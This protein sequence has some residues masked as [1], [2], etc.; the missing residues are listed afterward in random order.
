MHS[1][2]DF[3][4]M[5]ALQLLLAALLATST[6]TAADDPFVGKW[7]LNPSKCTLTD[8]MKVEAA[9]ANKYALIF[10]G[11]NA[12]TIVADGTDQP[13]LFGT[14]VSITVGGPNAWTVVRKKDGR[15]LLTGI[16]N[17]SADGMTL[18]DHYKENRA[19]GST[20]SLDY[21]YKRTAGSTG[22]PGTWVSTSEKVNSAYELDIEPWEG[23]GLSFMTPAQ[24]ETRN[25]KFDGKNYPNM[26]PDVAAGSAS[27]GHRVSGDT[28]EMTDKIEDKVMSTRRIKL[29]QDQNTLTMTVS[30]AG[31]TMPNILVFDRDLKTDR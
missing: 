12:E 7:K 8:Q 13:G 29:S 27:S 31:Q 22:F 16:W 9:G 18:T 28:L 17:L 30:P 25:M 14:T 26:G 23:D 21:V 10:T 1:Q 3:M 11:T 19:D 4:V 24:H 2:E 6:L 15:T 5:R 20:F